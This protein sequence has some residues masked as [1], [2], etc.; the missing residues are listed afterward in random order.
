MVKMD[1]E[2]LKYDNLHFHRMGIGE[3]EGETSISIDDKEEMI[4]INTLEN[5]LKKNGDYKKHITYLKFDVEG[6]ELWNFKNWITSDALKYVDQLG[7]EMHT[8][9]NNI[10]KSSFDPCNF[11]ALYV[12]KCLHD[13]LHLKS[14]VSEVILPQLYCSAMRVVFGKSH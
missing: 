6:Q 11:M 10:G 13:F 7:I 5:I 12:S 9:N 1:P 14:K 3:A 8:C 4:N 2:Y